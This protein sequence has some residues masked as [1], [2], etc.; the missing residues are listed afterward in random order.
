MAPPE[1]M[2]SRG[3]GERQPDRLLNRVAILRFI[4]LD[5]QCPFS[6]FNLPFLLSLAVVTPPPGALRLRGTGTWVTYPEG[7]TICPWGSLLRRGQRAYPLW[8]W[9]VAF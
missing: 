5:P 6:A 8:A 2:G 4:D 7:C 1:V 9:V 3:A